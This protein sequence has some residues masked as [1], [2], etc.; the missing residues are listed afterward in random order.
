MSNVIDFG[1]L[2][3]QLRHVAQ[4]V[5]SSQV[6]ETCL[7]DTGQGSFFLLRARYFRKKLN[8]LERT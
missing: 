5:S 1:S 7:D 4:T 8:T 6:P 3:Q 2:R